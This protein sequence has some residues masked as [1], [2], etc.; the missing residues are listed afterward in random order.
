MP[1]IAPLLN[2]SKSKNNNHNRVESKAFKRNET[3]LTKLPHKCLCNTE[4]LMMKY[5]SENFGGS[6]N[7]GL[8]FVLSILLCFKI[9]AKVIL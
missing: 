8:R 9:P 4:Q 1:K 6:K 3:M 7:Y 5:I 2:N